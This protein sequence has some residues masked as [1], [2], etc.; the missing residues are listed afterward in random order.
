MTKTNCSEC[1][2]LIE[3]EISYSD[4]SG[5]LCKNCHTDYIIMGRQAYV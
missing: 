5:Y 2:D 1:L 4:E 3:A